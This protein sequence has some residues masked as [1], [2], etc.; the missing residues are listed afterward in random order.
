MHVAFRKWAGIEGVELPCLER[1]PKQ[2]AAPP[3]A[4]QVWKIG[5]LPFSRHSRA[6]ADTRVNENFR[7]GK[8]LI[9]ELTPMRAGIVLALDLE[10]LHFGLQRCAFQAEATGSPVRSGEHAAGG[11]KHAEDVLTFSIV[12]AL[13]RA[14]PTMGTQMA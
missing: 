2:K 1:V 10:A 5:S 4:F 7:N 8:R 11:A 3:V 12:Q 9:F 14:Q 13:I 6:L